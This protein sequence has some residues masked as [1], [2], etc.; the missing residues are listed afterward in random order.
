MAVARILVVGAE[1]ELCS[2]IV[3]ILV[4][5]GYAV[6]STLIG[7]DVDYLVSLSPDLVI[8]THWDQ[9]GRHAPADRDGLVEAVRASELPLIVITGGGQ[10]PEDLPEWA[11]CFPVPPKEGDVREQLLAKVANALNPQGG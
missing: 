9:L 4:L 10:R 8:I 7:K 11:S 3:E 5:E 1:W 6:T 2:M